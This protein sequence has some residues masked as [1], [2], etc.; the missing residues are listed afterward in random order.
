MSEQNVKPVDKI[1]A[2]RD[3][4]F[5]AAS[6]DEAKQTFRWPKITGKFNWAIDWFDE[7]GTNNDK[8]ALII[9]D[10]EAN[11]TEYSYQDMVARSN[12]VA[13]WMSAQG[14]KKGDRLMLMLGNQIELWDAMLAAMKIG[15]VIIPTAQAV[16]SLDL[17]DRISR[18]KIRAVIANYA[19][20][21]KFDEIK[22]D[23]I[24]IIAG[25]Q[26]ATGWLELDQAYL[27]S[28]DPL[29]VITETSDPCICYF[30]SGTTSL[31]KMVEHSQV[32]YPVGHL[33]TAYFIG[34]REGGMHLNISS[35]GWGKHA[36]SSFFS[37]WIAEGV[38]CALNYSR[39]DAHKMIDLLT[40]LEINSL[41]APPTVW[42]MMLREELGEKP[43]GLKQLVSAGEPLTAEIIEKFEQTWGLTIRDGFGQTETTCQIGNVPGEPVKSGSMGRALPGVPIVILDQDH[44]LANEGEICIALEPFRPINLMTR[45][46]DDPQLQAEIEN[47]G[48]YH[49]GDLAS[50]DDNGYITYIGRADDVFKA[51]DYKVS[52][53]E[54]ESVLL[55]HPAVAEVGV[56]PS[57][58][59]IRMCVPKAYVK[60]ADGYEPSRE[61]ALE[62]LSYAKEN[63]SAYLRLRKVSFID[64]L[65]KTISQKIRRVVLRLQEYDPEWVD[66]N[67]YCYAD[68]AELTHKTLAKNS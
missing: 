50:V 12:Q 14:I 6:L 62:I 40:K 2:A 16:N 33:T 57:P 31:P 48:Y 27:G 54:L 58:D 18:G 35:P 45:Y 63:L 9:S 68:F 55:R 30:T 17:A 24:K 26:S 22:A 29:P 7:I 15:A 1:R 37:P 4:L 23:L 67:E 39:F 36:W 21:Y 44:N 11:T 42:R 34:C 32:S 52:P 3:F 49:T 56:V 61:T 60:L 38:I 25:S 19:N 41:C 20:A 43:A 13:H 46:I 51:S 47:H 66:E 59:P 28:A 65:P 64:E 10:L 8:P 5:N 53:F